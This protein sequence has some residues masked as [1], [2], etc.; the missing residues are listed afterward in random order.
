MHVTASCFFLICFVYVIYCT[1]HSSGASLRGGGGQGSNVKFT[2]PGSK[3][4]I[5]A[6]FC[7]VVWQ[8]WPNHMAEYG[9]VREG[10]GPLHV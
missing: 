2:A 4:Y 5:T 6:L 3:F 7:H 1:G 9:N 8:S 10:G